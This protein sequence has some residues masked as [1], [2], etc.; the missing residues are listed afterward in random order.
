MLW[1]KHR[2]QHRSASISGFTAKDNVLCLRLTLRTQISKWNTQAIGN[3]QA[4]GT[5]AFYGCRR[6]SKPA[7]TQHQYQP[8]LPSKHVPS[9]YLPS[10]YLPSN[11]LPSLLAAVHLS[12]T[13]NYR[14]CHLNLPCGSSDPS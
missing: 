12:P 9:N 6:R 10:N 4:I 1:T 2:R 8:C 13:L 11:Y 5:K 3:A 14:T 7:W